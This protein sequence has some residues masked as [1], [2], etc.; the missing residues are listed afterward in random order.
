M[1]KAGGKPMFKPLFALVFFVV[2]SHIGFSQTYPQG[3]FRH[4]LNIPMELVANFGE[5]RT[6]HWHMGLDIRTQQRENL[7]VYAAADG[8]V[9]RVLVEPGGFGQ[10]IYIN[11]PNGYTTLYAHLNKFY[12]ELEDYVEAAQHRQESWRVDLQLQ[13]GQFPVKK[14]QQIAL[15]GNTGGS[16]GPHVHFEIRDTKTDKVLNPLLFKFPIADAVPPA[17]TRLAIYDRNK[18]T[19]EQTPRLLPVSSVSGRTLS[20]GSNKISFAIGTV[21]YF[22]RSRNPV[23]VY[24]ARVLLDD[25]PVSGFVLDQIDYI[26]TRWMNAH[27]DYRMDARGGASV[28]H[29]SPLP[30][31]SGIPYQKFKDGG[32][33]IL[34]DTQPHDVAIEVKDAAGN[35]SRLKFRVQWDGGMDNYDTGKEERLVPNLINIFERSD[36]QLFTTEQTVYDTIAVN[37]KTVAG[38]AGATSPQHH[39]MDKTV[40]AHD[41]VTVRIKPQRELTEAERDR[42]VIKNTFGSRTYYSRAT[43]VNGWAEAKFRQFGV[44]QAFLDEEPPRV[45][46]PPTDLSKVSRIVFTPTDNFSVKSFRAELDGK[47][48]MFTNDKGRN[49]IYRFD[50][51]FPR[52][53]HELKVIVE[54][55]AGNVTEKTWTV[56]R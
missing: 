47:W 16:A 17:I 56:R 4:P 55:E 28:Q 13:P 50:H 40:P 12:R 53:T 23:G 39:F 42:V 26:E 38:G 46:A 3:Y 33:V 49:W 54:D 45:N 8:Y 34:H 32:M 36:F 7:P 21:D 9:A 48:L 6:N 30:G 14:G 25:Q 29:L 22:S 35:T 2:S 1:K 51:R 15:S 20:V 27:I 41:A 43:W 37:Y 10:A 31:A 52:G 19:W 5:L 11:H 24:T 18:S 44:Y